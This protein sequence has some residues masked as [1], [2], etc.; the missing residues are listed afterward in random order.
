MGVPISFHLSVH[1]GLYLP[2]ESPFG[3]A[4]EVLIGGIA[5]R[6]DAG[7]F[8]AVDVRNKWNG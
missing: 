6:G 4:L 2:P 8:S 3:L 7:T 5:L 1:T